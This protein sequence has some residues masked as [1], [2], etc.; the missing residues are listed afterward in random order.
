MRDCDD[1][2]V[3]PT[4]TT[5]LERTLTYLGCALGAFLFSIG[6]DSFLF[7]L[8]GGMNLETDTVNSTRDVRMT[9]YCTA[10]NW[11]NQSRQDVNHTASFWKKNYDNSSLMHS[12]DTCE[13]DPCSKN[14]THQEM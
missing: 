9:W 6:S 1:Y 5:M 8:H 2:C 13:T 3:P 10:Q 7:L 4:L 12:I 11:K 14:D